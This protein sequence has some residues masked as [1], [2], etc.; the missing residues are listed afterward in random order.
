MPKHLRPIIRAK[1]FAR[2]PDYTHVQEMN[3]SLSENIIDD[4]AQGILSELQ[5]TNPALFQQE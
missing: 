4:I 1:I 2:Y 3:E 5:T